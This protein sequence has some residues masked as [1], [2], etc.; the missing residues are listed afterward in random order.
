[1]ASRAARKYNA[2]CKALYERLR[3]KGKPHKVAIIAIVNKLI[4]QVFALVKSGSVYDPMYE[5][6][7][8]AAK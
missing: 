2:P 5:Q 7:K 4:K 6:S 8:L 3:A 1:M